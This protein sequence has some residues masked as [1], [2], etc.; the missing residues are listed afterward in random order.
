MTVSLAGHPTG[1]TVA[2]TISDTGDG[3]EAADLDR[4]Q[5]PYYT[6]KPG[7]TGLGL[8]IVHKI[9]DAHQ[10]RLQITSQANS[11]TQV[12]VLLPISKEEQS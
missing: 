1:E 12:T 10:A 7:G 4:I 2:I 9:L 6:T 11:G 5:D 8:A 3:I